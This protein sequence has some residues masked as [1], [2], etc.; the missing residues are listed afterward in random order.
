MR[1]FSKT[2]K[3]QGQDAILIQA[4]ASMVWP[5][6]RDSK[7]MESW[8]P[9]VEKVEV[10]LL[11]GQT[12]EGVGAE[13]TVHAKFSEKRKGWYEEVR[14]EQV[15]HTSISFLITKDSF[16]MSKM[17]YDVGAKME[18]R[19]VSQEQTEFVFTFYHRPK[20]VL[21]W[22]MNPMIKADQKKNRL[23]ALDSIK[24]YIETGQAIKN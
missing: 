16:G 8:G 13:R 10:R 14:T 1:R 21:G 7:T 6:I 22:L 23:K 12:L 18:L 11:P 2:P 24:S 5:M 20:N 17:L 19:P 9:P 3:V 15:E 4:P